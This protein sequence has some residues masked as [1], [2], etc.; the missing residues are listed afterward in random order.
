MTFSISTTFT[1]AMA[2]AYILQR[3]PS[4]PEPGEH[5]NQRQQRQRPTV[6]ARTAA[7]GAPTVLRGRLAAPPAAGPAA[8]PGMTALPRRARTAA[9]RGA[10]RIRRAHRLVPE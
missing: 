7:Q 3:L 4:S 5:G 8:A 1:S 6:A 9:A 10:R 2:P